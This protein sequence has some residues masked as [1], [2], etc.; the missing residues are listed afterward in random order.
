[1]VYLSTN[2]LCKHEHLKVWWNYKGEK[3]K[4]RNG[5]LPS[6]GRGHS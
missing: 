2:I 5:G 3:E 1:M 4:E 6:E